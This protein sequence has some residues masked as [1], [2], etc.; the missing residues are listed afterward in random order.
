LMII[1]CSSLSEKSMVTPYF[2]RETL[3]VSRL[4]H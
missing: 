1:C 2:G 4:P 3:R